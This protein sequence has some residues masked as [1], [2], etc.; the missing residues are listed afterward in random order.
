MKE[1]KRIAKQLM[2]IG[3]QRNDA[4]AFVRTYRKIMDANREDLFPEIIK[5]V[6]PV[7]FKAVNVSPYRLRVSVTVSDREMEWHCQHPDDLKRR[8]VDTLASRLA[9]ELA[10]GTM[11]IEHRKV[12]GAVEFIGTVNVI[13]PIEWDKY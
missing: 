7:Q 12:N 13:H 9:D 5:P 10:K 3:V 11:K 2:A 1:H 4:A 8:A 6:V